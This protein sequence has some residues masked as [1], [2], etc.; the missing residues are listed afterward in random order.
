MLSKL[1]YDISVFLFVME[2]VKRWFYVHM[3]RHLA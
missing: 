1:F 3:G 2:F